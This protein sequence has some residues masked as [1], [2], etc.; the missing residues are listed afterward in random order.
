MLG[1]QILLLIVIC[2]LVGMELSAPGSVASMIRATAQVTLSV[3]DGT[4]AT[5][6]AHL[7]ARG[8]L[9]PAY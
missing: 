7:E 3:R 1:V 8:A 2:F 6:C 4:A 9:C 5:L